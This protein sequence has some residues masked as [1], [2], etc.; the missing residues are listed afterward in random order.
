MSLKGLKRPI[1]SG[2]LDTALLTIRQTIENVNT[3]EEVEELEEVLD[4][5]MH[6]LNRQRTDTAIQK[7]RSRGTTKNDISVNI[8]S[9]T[10]LNFERQARKVVAENIDARRSKPDAIEIETISP[11]YQQIDAKIRE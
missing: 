3:D 11:A 5:I 6:H 10:S 8:D 9:S 4:E 2:N 1:S 7:R